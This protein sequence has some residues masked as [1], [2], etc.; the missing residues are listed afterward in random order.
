MCKQHFFLAN[1]DLFG[2]HWLIDLYILLLLLSRTN[3]Q[4]SVYN[5]NWVAYLGGTMHEVGHNL[6]LRHAFENGTEYEDRTGYMG[7]MPEHL[8]YPV[9]CTS[10]FKTFVW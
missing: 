5:N 4:K 8:R 1:V 3:N 10:P 6:G 7:S 2:L 9:Q